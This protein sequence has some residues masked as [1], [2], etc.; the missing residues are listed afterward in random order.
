MSPMFGKSPICVGCPRCGAQSGWSCSHPIRSDVPV[1]THEERKKAYAMAYPEE[2]SSIDYAAVGATV[3]RNE[4]VS[5]LREMAAKPRQD[6]INS[7]IT[8][9]ADQIESGKL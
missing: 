3:A 5:R 1:N 9:L 8:I 7:F 4:I 2:P 6:G